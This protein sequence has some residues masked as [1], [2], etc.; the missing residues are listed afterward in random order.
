MDSLNLTGLNDEQVAESRSLHGSN[1]EIKSEK[2]HFL[3]VLADILSEPLFIILVFTS[4]IYFVLDQTDEGIIMIVALLF[5]AGISLYQENKSNNALKE[6]NKINVAKARVIRNGKEIIIKSEDIVLNDLIIAEHGNI[7]PADAAI[8]KCNDLSIN[9]SIL[10]G[11]SLPSIKSVN[12]ESNGDLTQKNKIFKGTMVYEGSCIARVTAIGANTEI[13]KIGKK[14]E[15]TET[16]KSSLQIQIKNFVKKM[17]ATGVVA[18][19][20]VWGINYFTTHNLLGSLLSGLT[21]AMSILPEEIPVAFSTFMALGAFYLYKKKIIVRS[22]YTVETLGAATVICADKTGTITQNEM[23]LAA[24]YDFE[25]NKF[26][27]FTKEEYQSSIV[28]EYAMWASETKPYD[29]ME[30]SIHEVYSKTNSDDKRKKFR[31]TFEYPLSGHPPIMTHVFEEKEKPENSIIACKGALESILKQCKLTDEE[32]TKIKN[33]NTSLTSKGYR[34][35]AIAK[36]NLI[37]NKLPQTQ[38]EI[39]FDFLGLTAFYDPPKPNIKKVIKEFYNA[40]IDVK[41][42]TGDNAETTTAIASQIDFEK[43]NEILTGN[44]I[45]EMSNDELRMKVNDVKI[46]ARMYPEA[47]QKVIELLKQNNEI[48]A[49]TGDGVNDAPALKSAHIGIAMGQR[50]SEV[51]KKASS[52]I[53]MNDDLENMVDAI[54]LGRRI[55]ENLKKAIRYIISIHIPIILVVTLPLLLFWKYKFIFFPVHVIFLELI[56]G[57]TCSIIYEREPIEKNSMRKKPRKMQPNYFSWHELS[58]SIIQGLA[59]TLVCL[60]VGYFFMKNDFSEEYVR[61]AIFSTLIFS[62]VMLTLVNRSFYYPISETIKYKNSLIPLII[63][64]SFALLASTI[65]VPQVRSLFSFEI[66]ELKD[67]AICFIAAFVGVNWVELYKIYLRRIKK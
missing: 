1:S 44:Q 28:L 38:F 37:N 61:T 35:L 46:F 22:P 31:M 20:V 42:I 5:V 53:L 47:K 64:I 49:M 2:N 34:V 17:V 29:H 54:A 3:H 9:E 59:I 11:E 25:N 7:I 66:I 39:I 24:I 21:L 18:F 13:G 6:L 10:T 62:N 50:G 41:I 57:P 32:L 63:T 48:V 27:D 23:H 16:S 65:Y 56:M 19:V 67:M 60:T 43:G 26:F 40:G 52:L 8:L 58:L 33:C 51:A 14:L 36:S 55:Y 30:K 4:V 45:M 15:E 12:P